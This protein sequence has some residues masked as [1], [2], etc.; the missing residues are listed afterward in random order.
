VKWENY[1]EGEGRRK[2]KRSS[3][4]GNIVESQT[5]TREKAREEMSTLL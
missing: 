3:L 4:T 2:A 5:A 1:R